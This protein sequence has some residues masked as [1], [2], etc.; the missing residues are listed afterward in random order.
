MAKLA[1]MVI[2]TMLAEKYILVK[3]NCFDNI[4]SDVTYEA[5]S[6]DP[7]HSPSD[8]VLDNDRAWCTSQ[9]P[10]N[11]YL[12]VY[13][14]HLYDVCGIVIQGF[15]NYSVDFFTTNYSLSFSK[16]RPAWSFLL[17]NDKSPKE[18]PIAPADGN[19]STENELV[20]P[21]LASAVRIHPIETNGP[22]MCLRV[23][24]Y[25][26]RVLNVACDVHLLTI[27]ISKSSLGPA[28]KQL[29]V[30]Q[31]IEGCTFDVD[32]ST[33][34]TFSI[35]V[36]TC[37]TKRW[38][39]G[40]YLFYN[41][42]VYGK[43]ESDGDSPVVY[44]EDVT[45]NATCV[46]NR[47]VNV[48]AAFL[49]NANFTV[50]VTEYGELNFSMAA[51]K[52][53]EHNDKITADDQPLAVGTRLYIKVEVRSS[54][55]ELDLLLER[56]YATPSTNRQDNNQRQFIVGGCPDLEDD[57]TTVHNCR[58][59]SV[60]AFEV[61]VFRFEDAGNRIYFYCDVIVCF[62]GVS[63]SI[64]ND[65]CEACSVNARRRRAEDS[66]DKGSSPYY[67]KIGP[68][69]IQKATTQK[70]QDIFA[71][72]S[73]QGDTTEQMVI[74]LALGVA[75]LIT[76]VVTI[77]TVVVLMRKRSPSNSDHTKILAP[78]T[79]TRTHTWLDVG[80]THTET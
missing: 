8:A 47:N 50:D 56:C 69:Q 67:L 28:V 14:G 18:F 13:L 45:F 76:L 1:L 23:G 12:E 11:E 22:P 16:R 24:V 55:E 34:T 63:R 31:R 52:D 2:F 79:P 48:T 53:S 32:P 64:C 74:V 43:A 70:E 4:I 6:T 60:Q 35:H 29:Y 19:S 25:G 68:F 39:R 58:N 17:D 42:I 5:T 27:T 38:T 40:N 75:A 21:R 49:P 10:P 66:Y 62:A 36:D 37:G 80:G 59:S 3:G 20:T 77:A 78:G 33:E 26:T 9:P 73:N 41:N 46:F 71:D 30:G 54:N 7:G 44:S 51:F 65:H 57:N 15:K 72:Q 61:D